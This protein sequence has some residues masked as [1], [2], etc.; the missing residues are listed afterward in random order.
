MR[1][2][3]ARSTEAKERRAGKP[4]Y[5]SSSEDDEPAPPA[6]ARELLSK[7][8]QVPLAFDELLERSVRPQD[9]VAG[10]ASESVM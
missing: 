10:L 1:T 8:K 5:D 3:G 7:I 4:G 9:P 6:V 2:N